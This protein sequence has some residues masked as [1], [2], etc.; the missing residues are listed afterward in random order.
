MT[1]FQDQA[2]LFIV[3]DDA[4]FRYL[5]EAAAARSGV[6]DPITTF[7]DGRAALEA[8]QRA[9]PA[10]LPSLVV[11]DLCMPRMT[12]LEL[13]HALKADPHTRHIP[14]AILTS[15]DT[16]QDREDAMQAGAFAFSPKPYGFDAL[17]LLLMDLGASCGA[18]VPVHATGSG[19]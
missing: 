5:I 16:P 10:G 6:F 8:I 1:S 9:S 3:E 18:N 19:R 2:A 12:G 17:M 13:I 4:N 14:I 7:G 15:S 11:S